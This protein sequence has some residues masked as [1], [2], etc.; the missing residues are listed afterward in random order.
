MA[1]RVHRCLL[2]DTG[3]RQCLAK[4]GLDTAFADGSGGIGHVCMPARREKPELV[5]VRF[6]LLAQQLQRF[7]RQR[8]VAVFVALGLPDAHESARTVDVFDFQMSAL[9]QAQSAGIDR[10]QTEAIVLKA[11]AVQHMANFIPA[12]HDRQ[13]FV[14]PG[15]DEQQGWPRALD[16]VIVEELDATQC[17]RA[18][19]AAPL[20]DVFTVQ[21][22]L[23]QI[24]FANP[25]RGLVEVFAQLAN[26]ADIQ[27]L[28]TGAVAFKLQVFDHPLS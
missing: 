22:V 2:M 5:A 20:F 17:D 1:K 9:G 21:K 28:S 14:F 4:S 10:G 6:P 13:P 19:A 11:N 3:T 15:T 7:L 18:G 12:E 8:H 26:G 25:A 24:F 27:F 23:P 16:G